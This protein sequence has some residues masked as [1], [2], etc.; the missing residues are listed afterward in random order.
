MVTH[1]SPN[2]LKQYLRQD[3]KHW[4]QVC[5]P[6]HVIYQSEQEEKIYIRKLQLTI[7][8]KFNLNNFHHFFKYYKCSNI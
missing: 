5:I 3:I 6:K 8:N 1:I 2:A 4:F 7:Q